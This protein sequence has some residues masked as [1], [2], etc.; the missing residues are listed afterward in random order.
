MAPLYVF[1][2]SVG[3]E[4]KAL[5][6]LDH[7]AICR[8]DLCIPLNAGSSVELMSYDGDEYVYLD[9]LADALGF[10]IQQVKEVTMVTTNDTCGSNPGDRPPEFTLPDLFTGESVS[11]ADYLGRKV[12]FYMWASW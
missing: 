5:D 9:V 6:G 3:A 8:G 1:A 10:L 4:V 11:S 2:D 12:V 7:P